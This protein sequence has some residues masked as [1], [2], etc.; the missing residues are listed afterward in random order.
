MKPILILAAVTALALASA[1]SKPNVEVAAPAVVADTIYTDGYI[2]TVNDAQ[3]TVEALAVKDG[4]ILAV[5]ARSE[6]EKSWKG[7]GTRVVD[8]G[9]KTLVPGFI[10]GHSH[11]TDSLAAAGRANISAPPVGPAS[12]A[13]EIVATL[14][15]FA[16]D[17]GVKPGELIVGY[18]YDENMMPKG[19]EP[20]RDVLDR[21]FPDNP[22]MIIHVSAHGAVLN[23]AAFAKFGYKDGMPTPEGGV[24]ARKPGTQDLEGLV[25]E[26]GYLQ[27]FS[28]LPQ[29][30]EATEVAAAKAGQQ[31]YAAAGVTTAQE[32]ATHENQLKQLQRLAAKGVLF[33]DVV[34]YPFI[35]D[36]DKILVRNPP[37][38]FGAYTN[39]LKLGGC[40]I[41][42]DGSPQG[43]TAFFTTP[44]LTGGPEGQKDWKG[45]PTFPQDVMNAGVK[46][47]YDAG[48]QVLFHANGDAAI[49]SLLTAHE[50]A[51]AGS[52]DKD[53]RTTV[54]HSQFVRRDQLARFVKYR[55]IPSFFTDHTFFF[56]DTHV[57][58]RG[59]EQAY[60]LSPMKSAYALG[61]RPANH[62]DYSVA[63]IDHLMT[64]W[65]AVNRVS[66]SGE[67]IGPDERV[68]PLQ[69]LK[70][71]TINGAYIYREEASKGSLQPGKLADLV[72]LDRNPLTVDPM[73]IRDIK[74]VETIKEGKTIYQAKV[75][76]GS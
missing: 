66:R 26:T 60:F 52:L 40:K 70:A 67:V 2:V 27:A 19:Q 30:T 25:M 22:V 73:A 20:T 29:V 15:T 10:D 8:L 71:I 4:R 62:T 32:G 47:C 63:P 37:A 6:I 69:A 9:G 5:G 33:L 46:K 57:K 75:R 35:L 74:V 53:R 7:Q 59:R 3:P 45:E 65:T 64:I 48:L 24:I 72:I 49:D 58:N 44:Y 18:G 76:S 13:T 34:S 68:T 12:N 39:H 11:F 56:G 42:G 51:A 38:T 28:N 61:L 17:T 43:R 50:A 36:L 55:F 31:I 23:S 1:C 21:A 54:I 14:K 16:H 41:V